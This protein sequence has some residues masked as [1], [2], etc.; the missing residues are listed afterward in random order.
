[1]RPGGVVA[2]AT[3]SP[4]LA[5]TRLVVDDVLKAAAR[6]GQGV[7]RLDTPAVLAQVADVPGAAA[8]TAVQL[9]PHTHGTDAMHVALLRRT[10]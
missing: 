3:C 10:S 1:V 7:E 5:E 2:Y 6:K 8:G 4:V 9:W